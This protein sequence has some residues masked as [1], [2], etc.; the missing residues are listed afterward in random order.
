MA[1]NIISREKTCWHQKTP[2]T[3]SATLSVLTSFYRPNPVHFLLSP[4]ATPVA[5]LPLSPTSRAASPHPGHKSHLPTPPKKRREYAASNAPHS[6]CLSAKYQ[7]HLPIARHSVTYRG[8]PLDAIYAHLRITLRKLVHRPRQIRRH[9]KR[10][11]RNRRHNLIMA[12]RIQFICTDPMVSAIARN[13]SNALSVVRAVRPSAQKILFTYNVAS[14]ASNPAT[15]FPHIGCPPTTVNRSGKPFSACT[16]LR[17]SDPYPAPAPSQ[18]SHPTA[19]SVSKSSVRVRRGP[20]RLRRAAVNWSLPTSITP[21]AN[22]GIQCRA[23]A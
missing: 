5:P 3:V 21:R 6:H 4:C 13:V 1:L 16:I 9:N 22:A 20:Q 15:S 19:E 11:M 18:Q 2:R 12:L 10:H 7:H 14:R 8:I 17:W 23:R